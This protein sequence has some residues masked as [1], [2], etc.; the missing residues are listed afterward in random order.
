VPVAP[1]VPQ[2]NITPTPVLQPPV[3]PNVTDTKPNATQIVV[4]RD[5]KLIE[6]TVTV[7]GDIVVVRQGALDRPFPKSQVQFVA[8]NKDEV[9]KFML[10]K[11]PANDVAARL[12][13]ARWCVFSGMREQGLAE[14]REIQ[15]MQPT[16]ASAN[17]LIRAL[18]Q[19]LQQFPPA[20][21][22][23]MGAPA[24]PVFPTVTLTTKPPVVEPEPDIAPEAIKAF[25]T[26]VQPFLANQCVDCHSKPDYDGKFKLVYVKPN[27]ASR[28]ATRA[29][30]RAVVE[31]LRKDEPVLSPFLAKVLT[32][33]G[34]QTRAS[35][36]GRNAVAY[37]SLEAWVALAV[38]TPIMP[39][40]AV[41]PPS[42]M[43]VPSYPVIPPKPVV[44]EPATPVLPPAM[45]PV[46]E[47]VLPLPLPVT[48]PAPLPIPPSDP[49]LPVPVPTVPL[50]KPT[51]PAIPPASALPLPVPPAT[52][53]GTATPPKPP[54][55]G[56]TGGD[57]F[58]PAGFNETAPKK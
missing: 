56:P 9:Y 6:G 21:A 49:L 43:P 54:V 45:P 31:Q 55:T 39:T 58:D 3:L 8:E 48:T 38:D 1:S 33:H 2:A 25:P 26:R 27:E 32:A 24:E 34:G 28:E 20:N 14:A 19:S 22:P 4:L 35:V 12:K 57:E 51:A 16:N 17:E 29:N 52:P 15:K 18:E 37:Q 13:V 46:T 23:K 11:V 41:P 7:K 10:A 42:P 44:T 5:D 30:L 50:P 53:F 36:A 47:P 40:P